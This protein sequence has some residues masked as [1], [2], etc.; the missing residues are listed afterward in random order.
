MLLYRTAKPP[1]LI[2]MCVSGALTLLVSSEDPDLD[3]GQREDSDGLRNPLL[4]LVFYSCG[5]Q[6]LDALQNIIKN[7][8]P[9]HTLL[10][11]L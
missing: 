5:P 8:V 4:Q 7:G 9:A 3:V 2:K 1:L 6:E 10:L 11:V